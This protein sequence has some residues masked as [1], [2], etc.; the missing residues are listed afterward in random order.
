MALLLLLGS[1][2]DRLAAQEQKPDS[3]F[4]QALKLH[5][6]GDLPGAAQA[7][8]AFLKRHPES[9]E[10][11]SNLG[12]VYARLGRYQDAIE[13][14]M[15]ALDRDDQNPGVR[16][17]LGVAYY[18][19]A[20]IAKASAEFEKVVAASPE[21]K[22]AAILLSDCRLRMGED[23]KVI[24]L[25]APR[26]ADYQDDPAMM[27]L[28]GTALIR[29]NQLQK[30]QALIDRIL[31][32]GDS[33]QAHIMLGTASTMARD[34][35]KAADEFARAIELDPKLPSAH[36]LY[37]RAVMATGDPAK[38]ID[39]F[40]SELRIDSNDFDSNLYLGVL[41]KQDQKYA[42]ALPY[43]RRALEVRPGAPD[44]RYQ[45]ASL[46]FS[47]GNIAGAEKLLEDLVKESPD[48]V[49]AHVS[50]ATIYYRLK[51]KEEG[52]RERD[53]VRKLN[54]ETQ[55]STQPAH[56]E[57]ARR[58]AEPPASPMPDASSPQQQVTFETLSRRANAAREA[59]RVDE[60]IRLYGDALE[61]KPDWAE[62]WWN[63]G[64]TLYEDDRYGEARP[65]FEKLTE[66]KDKGGSAWA[67]LGLCEFQLKQ[68]EPA[69]E[70]LRRGRRV[71]LVEKSR[72]AEVAAYHL[73]VLLNRSGQSEAAME[74]LGALAR[75]QPED[76]EIIRALG[77]SALR[78]HQL[79]AEL[80][81]EKQ[82]LVMKAGRAEYSAAQPKVEE[83]RQ[84]F[85]ELLA[86]YPKQPGVHLARGVFLMTSNADA[87][88]EEFQKELEI[89]SDDYSANF[90]AGA[91]YQEHQKFDQALLYLKRALELRPGDAPARYR[92]GAL[93]LSLENLPEAQRI[94][95]ELT[96]EAP[97]FLDAHV[98][99]ATLYFRLNRKEDG[100]RE[101]EIV[102]KLTAVAQG[103]ELPAEA[104]KAG[105]PGKANGPE[106]QKSPAEAQNAFDSLSKRADAAREADRAIEAVDLYQQ[107]LRI[108][109]DWSE[110]WWYL[111]TLYYEN[112]HYTE[113]LPAFGRV[114]ELKPKGGPSWAMM[115]L[116]EFELKDY[117]RSAEHLEKARTLGIPKGHLSV[118]VQYHF[119]VLLNRFGQSEA[120]LQFLYS[121]ARQEAESPSIV[122][123]LGLAALALPY[124]PKE[125]PTDKQD[126]VMKIGWAEY[127]MAQ[128]NVAESRNR[129]DELMV[130][131]AQTPGVHYAH[132]VF[133]LPSDP[134]GAV[135]EFKKELEFSPEHINAR[136]QIAFEYI[137]RDD[138]VSGMPYAEQA[139]KLA[140]DLFATHNALGRILLEMGRTDHAIHELETGLKLAPDSPET[141][142]ALARAYTRAGRKQDAERAR[143][144]FN[145][146]DKL[147][148]NLR[149]GQVTGPAEKPPG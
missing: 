10:A 140:P 89:N 127:Y 30:G 100:N 5:Q 82:E 143:A 92:L 69:L 109:P 40:R 91:L 118:V 38:A 99:L 142:Y 104:E 145:R 27:Y 33:A 98:S 25:L 137:K 84:R 83:A 22:N 21:N 106:P 45:I 80:A 94:L 124:L 130:A 11:H 59:N 120:A 41:L 26:E 121:L 65:A 139:V 86:A 50:L 110:G 146:L 141:C 56:L 35:K 71:G 16:F 102:R 64:T 105:V 129:F 74:I 47:S 60:A 6:S 53:I 123:A 90:Y 43:L 46:Q 24:E 68:F 37:G 44:V 125:L 55:A 51:R 36:A 3:Q 4:V 115:G 87:A 136:L 7:Y 75:Q 79:P 117:K 31:R 138:Y 52:D 20:Q 122:Q 9:V 111:G 17:N 8:Q 88:I 61:I 58:N 114:T 1:Q 149:E 133:L 128:R 131:Y 144:E 93:Y 113:A 147:R 112:D 32:N 108:K 134:D 126:L 135:A 57:A 63:L 96:K 107:A 72:L 66:L 148:R 62:G 12:A 13:Q 19:S 116:C 70:H 28:L 103:R 76:H 95:E 14:Y 2:T 49:E 81:P 34:Y 101:R 97:G 132:G 119:S 77:M 29:D 54:A 15:Q 39:A 73:A 67:M 18:D 23:K 85:D 42:E 48:F 78:L